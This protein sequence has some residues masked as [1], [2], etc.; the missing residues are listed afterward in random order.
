MHMSSETQSFVYLLSIT[1]TSLVVN[2]DAYIFTLATEPSLCFLVSQWHP[3][4][5][6]GYLPPAALFCRSNSIL[7]TSSLPHS[8]LTTLTESW[9][10]SSRSAW[11]PRSHSLFHSKSSA[12]GIPLTWTLV[13][14]RCLSSHVDLLGALSP[15]FLFL[16]VFLFC[17]SQT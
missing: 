12:V 17:V 8:K 7:P 13:M 3:G 16:C 11:P 10:T 2:K 6:G 15:L 9:K 4:F 14:T 5:A 1:W